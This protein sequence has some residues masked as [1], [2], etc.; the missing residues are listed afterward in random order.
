MIKHLWRLTRGVLA[1]RRELIDR[2]RA[3]EQRF[4][5]FA[6]TSS[7]WFWE[8]DADFR[9]VE[10]SRSLDK[11]GLDP[12][13]TL[14]RCRWELP[15]IGVSEAQWCTHRETLAR[16]E[17]FQNFEYQVETSPGL[18]R[19]FSVSGKPVFGTDGRFL[20]YRGTGKDI[21]ERKAAELALARLNRELEQRVAERT[22]EL[23][24]INRELEAFCYSISHDLRAPL[25]AINGYATILE[26]ALAT[27][28]SDEEH[29]HFG[30]IVKNSVRM[31]ELI[32]DI[33]EYSRVTRDALTRQEVDLDALARGVVAELAETYPAA[34]V[35]VARLPCVE[36]DP[37][38]LRQVYQNLIDN[39]L[40]YS[41]KCEAPRVEIGVLLQ[42]GKRVFYVQDN[43]AG[44]DM[45][46]AG[47]LFGV[48]QRMHP[49]SQFHGTGVGLAIVKRVIERHR[50]TVWAEAE[51]GKGACLYFTLESSA[52]GR[53]QPQ[54]YAAGC[55]Q[56]LA[57]QMA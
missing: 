5:D 37:T 29:Q 15:V 27:R 43:G 25:R 19:W 14:G 31:G 2:L 4:R 23:E 34:L 39:A 20:G 44:F 38:M 1:D 41:S 11:T 16:R 47:K 30:R 35:E 6:Q 50:G 18:L 3:S 33:L 52:G 45:R 49:E 24:Q 53:A 55:G 8:Q 28:L 36:G 32:D 17:P 46:F 40:K 42:D 10:M 21:T 9:F 22:V 56:R 48:F 54:A 7:D 12:A 26:E 57:A 51:P 13:R